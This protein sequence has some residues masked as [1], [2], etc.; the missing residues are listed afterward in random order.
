MAPADHHLIIQ[1]DH[2]HLSLGPKEQHHRPCINVTFRSAA[3][4][5]GDRVTGMI[6]SGEL[7]DGAAGLWEIKR[8]GGVAVVQ[9]PEEATFPSMPL[10]ALRDVKADYTVSIQEMGELLSRLSSGKR[11]QKRTAVESIEMARNLPT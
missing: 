2:V 9:H 10:S 5:Y 6:L 7:D 8:R 3:L 1:N 4:A 11:E